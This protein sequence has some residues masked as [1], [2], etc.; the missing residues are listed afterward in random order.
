MQ[1]GGNEKL[2]RVW[3]V[4]FVCVV[5][6]SVIIRLPG[7]FGDLWLDEIWTLRDLGKFDSAVEIFTKE[8]YDNNHYLNSLILYL[9]GSRDRWIIY[10]IHSLVAGAGAV[11]LAWLIGRRYGKAEAVFSSLLVGGAYSM[12]HFSSEARGYALVVFF[13]FA[14]FIVVRRFVQ[15]KSWAGAGLF[16]ACVVFGFT[17]HLTFVHI[18]VAAGVW[19]AVELFRTSKNKVETAVR[20]AQVFLVPIL[21]VSLFFVMTVSKINY[22]GGP[23]QTLFE[24]IAEP[25][26]HLVG[27]PSEGPIAAGVCMISGG[28]FVVG[29]L[30]L[31]SRGFGEWLFFAVVV[32]V[33]PVLVAAIVRPEYL[34]GRYFLVSVAFG[35]VVLGIELAGLWRGGR[36]CRIIAVVLTMLFFAGNG[37]HLAGFYRLG[38]GS[39]FEALRFIVEQTAKDEITIVSD[40]DFR[41][42]MLI[43]FYEKYLPADKRIVYLSKQD[44]DEHGAD[45]AIMH[46][47]LAAPGK[48]YVSF[49]DKYGTIYRCIKSVGYSGLSGMNWHIFRLARPASQG[50]GGQED[51]TVEKDGTNSEG[52][53]IIRN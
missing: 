4:V 2:R 8:H 7:M 41:N 31:R 28:L 40:H 25:L 12:I 3:P 15:S 34:P 18:F 11:V 43:D 22:G 36:V 20:F 49:T 13:G 47:T 29:I 17:S 23:D 1:N 10:R 33:S 21:F 46:K 50:P 6:A 37:W 26:S 5:L 19:L 39:Y 9:L 30:R 35:L 52:G 42:K 38:R 14:S 16:W 45:W 32:V 24:V 44:Y 53:H 48:R 27:G 51:K